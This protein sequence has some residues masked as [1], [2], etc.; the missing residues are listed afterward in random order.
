VKALYI[1]KNFR[2]KTLE[3]IE[4]CSGILDSYARD[5]YDLSLRQIYYRLVALDH[6]PEDRKWTRIEETGK[7]VRDPQGTK[8]ALPNYTWLG[9]LINEGRLAGRLDWEQIVDRGRW[10]ESNSHWDNPSEVV[11]S[12][13]D[14]FALDKW[15]PQ[16]YH[17][18][19]MCE[20]QALEGVLIPVCRKLD[21]PFS[22]NKGYSS[23]SFMWRKG[24]SLRYQLNEGK[25]VLILYVGDHDPSGLDMDRDILDRLRLFTKL[26]SNP[27]LVRGDLVVQRVALTME[28]IREHNPPPNPTKITDSRA[29]EYIKKYG[30]ES[31]ELDSVDPRTLA[32]LVEDEVLGVRDADLWAEAYEKEEKMKQ[33]LRDLAKEYAA[34]KW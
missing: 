22:S 10:T 30:D 25:K 24:Q 8:N 3:L 21:V 17:V 20:K 11:Q 7:W 2:S 6:F 31:W 33:P 14:S 29:K 34:K 16:P 9:N 13:A 26:D 23:Q 5:G 18:E 1:P 27:R 28:Q 15:E 19:V 32:K 4:L 12:A